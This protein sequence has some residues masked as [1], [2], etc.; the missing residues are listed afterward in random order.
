VSKNEGTR[1]ITN[2]LISINNESLV[3]TI[4][5][6]MVVICSYLGCLLGNLSLGGGINN[7][8]YILVSGL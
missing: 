5:M 2:T 4:I 6:A 1:Q 8:Q 3:G 7:Q